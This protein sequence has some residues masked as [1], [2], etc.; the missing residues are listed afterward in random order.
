[1]VSAILTLALAFVLSQKP[2]SAATYLYTFSFTAQD[3]LTALNV[4]HAAIEPRLGIFAF[5]L[6]PTALPGYTYVSETISNQPTDPW[7]GGTISDASL[8]NLDTYAYFAKVSQPLVQVI[9]T[10]PS[11]FANHNYTGTAPS[12]VF[13][14]GVKEKFDTTAVP[15][16]T[17]FTIT[18]SSDSINKPI[19]FNG[20]ASSV[21]AD[22][23]GGFGIGKTDTNL[24]FSLTLTGE[25]PEPGTWGLLLGG[26]G[27]ILAG[28]WKR[29]RPPQQDS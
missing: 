21:T 2:A 11:V 10:N 19:V 29:K 15:L 6:E 14:G 1:M 9:T 13:F 20:Y 16:S 8:P 4:N 5:F 3:V 22:S 24:D 12:P 25:A 7:S 27:L 23:T 26:I 17:V 18:V 28:T